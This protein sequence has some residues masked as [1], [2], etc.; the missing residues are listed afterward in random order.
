M[1]SKKFW[2]SWSN[3][4]SVSQEPKSLFVSLLFINQEL[5]FKLELFQL[6]FHELVLGK[7]HGS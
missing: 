4:Q 2:I 7:S 6:L 1:D 5:K 3:V